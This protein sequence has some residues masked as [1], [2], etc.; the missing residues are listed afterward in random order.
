M[1]VVLVARRRRTPVRTPMEI[2]VA[3][4]SRGGEWS[5]SGMVF[6]EMIMMGG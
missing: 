5:V 3:N 4:C 1:K 6:L 2:A